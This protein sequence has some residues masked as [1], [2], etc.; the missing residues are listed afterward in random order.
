MRHIRSAGIVPIVA[1]SIVICDQIVKWAAMRAVG[2]GAASGERWL[3]GDWLGLEYVRNTGVAFG[4][5]HG[6]STAALI[7]ASMAT[8]GAVGL[9]VWLHRASSLVLI[10]GALIGGGAVGNAIDRVRFGYVRDFFAVGPW[11]A[12]NIADAAITIGVALAAIGV[13]RLDLT[14]EQP[15]ATSNAGSYTVLDSTK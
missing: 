9:F 5:L 13:V 8:L 10:A 6:A 3:I 11:P 15:S 14:T 2:P 4:L 1:V 7:A 12:F